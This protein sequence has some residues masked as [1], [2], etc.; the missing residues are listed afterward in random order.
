MEPGIHQ[1]VIERF[2]DASVDEVCAITSRPSTFQVRVA[3]A[4]LLEEMAYFVPT[5]GGLLQS[6]AVSVV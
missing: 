3:V 5:A 1:V 6:N 2:L 4:V